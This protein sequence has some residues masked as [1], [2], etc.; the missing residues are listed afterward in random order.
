MTLQDGRQLSF[1]QLG[2]ADASTVFY[3]HGA[4]NSCLA[5]PPGD[6][7]TLDAGVRLDAM[8]TDA[9]LIFSA[10]DFDPADIRVPV[11]L[12]YGELDA[13]CPP[14]W[15]QRL[16]A[17]ISGSELTVVPGVGHNHGYDRSVFTTALRRVADASLV[18]R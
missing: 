7:G 8:M 3:F 14:S 1:E 15:G 10:W 9:E 18:V 2:P 12:V 11:Q 17:S 4:G 16:A 6:A 5:H 13:C